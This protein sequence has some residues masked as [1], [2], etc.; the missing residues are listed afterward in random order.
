VPCPAFRSGAVSLAARALAPELQDQLAALMV[1]MDGLR[2]A[3]AAANLPGISLQ[4]QLRLR[5]AMRHWQQ[6]VEA[7]EALLLGYIKRP[8][9]GQ[10]QSAAAAAAFGPG[11]GAGMYGSAAGGGG[12]SL[13]DEFVDLSMAAGGTPASGES[14]GGY[15]QRRGAGQ[16]CT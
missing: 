7:A 2:G 3:N 1:D 15:V 8:P 9:P 13:G 6:A 10:F 11:G 12:P 14:R 5:A 16:V 4:T